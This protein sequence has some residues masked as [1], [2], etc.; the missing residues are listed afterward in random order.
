MDS[1]Q[2]HTCDFRVVPGKGRHKATW[3]VS[4]KKDQ[5]LMT[6]ETLLAE[7]LLCA[8]PWGR[9]KKIVSPLRGAQFSGVTNASVFLQ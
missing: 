1:V 9:G 4:Y 5:T 3:E 7:G 8:R 2:I 6:V